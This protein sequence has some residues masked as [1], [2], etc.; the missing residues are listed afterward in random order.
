MGWSIGSDGSHLFSVEDREVL[1]IKFNPANYTESSLQQLK[2]KA[3][4]LNA[5]GAERDML[6]ELIRKY[7]EGRGMAATEANI[8]RIE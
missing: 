7:I 2:D 6:R 8:D 5:T 4:Q 3:L 1:R